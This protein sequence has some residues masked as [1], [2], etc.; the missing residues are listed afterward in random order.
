MATSLEE[1][2]Q[3]VE[4]SRRGPGLLVCAPHIAL[5]PT[6]RAVHEAA[7]GGAVGRL[8]TA[9]ARYGW[10]GPWWGEWFYR[11]GGG[12]LFDLGVYNVTSLCALF[13]PAYDVSPR[14][15]ASWSPSGPSTGG[16]STSR[17]TTTP[18]C[19][20]TSEAARFAVVTTGF[21][22]QKY[23]SPAIELYGD[24]GTIQLLGD[25]WAPEGWELWRNDEGAWRVYP[26][27]EP[28]WQ[29][30]VGLR[31][32][33]DC[34]E[35][36]RP[37]ITRPEHAYHALE[38]MLAA[39][40]AGR[41]GVARTSR[42]RLPRARVRRAVGRGGSGPSGSRPPEPR[43]AISRLRAQ[44]S[45]SRRRSAADDA[46]RH[47]WGDEESG[48]VQDWIYV[49]SERIH[50]IVFGLPPGES[51]R[52]SDSF[53]TVFAADELLHVLQGTLVLA[54]PETGEVVRA[55]PGDSVFFRRDTWHHGFS[56]GVD[57]LR[58]LEFF[59]P[60]PSTGTSGAYARTKPY[61]A[62]SVYADERAL[63]RSVGPA[64]TPSFRLLRPGDV[65]WRL[66]TGV[67]VGLLASTEHLTVATLR[68]LPGQ[69]SADES[70]AGDEFLYVT[71]GQLRVVVAGGAERH[72]RPGRR[73]LRPRRG[74]AQ[75]PGE[76]RGD[77]RGD[78]RVAPDYRADD[79]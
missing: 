23:R 20:S 54:N 58:V 3:L 48:L 32:L 47:I 31:H 75:V 76:R 21:T 29:W 73:L 44:R 50:A 77:R 25:D 14:W 42:E 35:T 39:Q 56:Y 71:A 57:D 64:E 43:W 62:E 4:L 18:T 61:L 30:T 52:H 68:V 40:A 7:R 51:F 49:S 5:S 70:H 45:R 53:R 8:L 19:C 79:R 72:A 65:T 46:V 78:R 74:P 1:A 66:D 36:G 33:V 69:S 9:R 12:S 60:P 26:E 11:P 59:A 41:D 38:I 28:H 10:A 24:E 13:G 16:R 27:S 63:G 67:L 34:V 55:E 22:M 2:V 15:S 17:P 37:T 6:F